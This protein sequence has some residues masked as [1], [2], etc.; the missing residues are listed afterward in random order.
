MIEESLQESVYFKPNCYTC[1]HR[2][3]VVGSAHSCCKHPILSPNLRM[4]MM[5]RY[6]NSLGSTNPTNIFVTI[7]SEKFP[8][9]EWDE[10]GVRNG[11]VLY[12][13]NFDPTWLEKCFLY[14]HKTDLSKIT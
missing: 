13:D 1:K 8:L 12:P 10:I 3:E 14:E 9:Q 2:G 11:Y 6:L 7:N 5:L 4:F